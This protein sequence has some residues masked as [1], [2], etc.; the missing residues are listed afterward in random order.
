MIMKEPVRAVLVCVDFADILE[1]TLAYNRHHFEQVLVVTSTTD[2]MTPQIARKND[3]ECLITDAFYER[4]AVFNKWAALEIGLDAMGRYGWICVMDADIMMPRYP[5]LFDPSFGCLYTPRRRDCRNW[6][7]ILPHEPYWRRYRFVN[8]R[9]EHAGYFQLFHADSPQLAD[10]PWYPTDFQW[11]GTAD[12]MFQQRFLER[13]KLRPP[14]E[15]MHLGE[16]FTNWAGRV[17]PYA[18]GTVPAEAEKRKGI[19]RS[20][21]Q[22]R[23]VNAGVDDRYQGERIV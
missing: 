18:D 5:R 7:T 3:A 23:R 9:E 8:A 22:Q 2:T 10:K 20:F 6:A 15:V 11:A 17:Q 13:H 12:T 1:H 19:F 16:P 14:F 4:G 21:L